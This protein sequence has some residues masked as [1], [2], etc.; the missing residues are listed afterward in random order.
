MKCNGCSP[1]MPIRYSAIVGNTAS[2]NGAHKQ[3]RRKV[4]DMTAR[5]PC[6]KPCL[7]YPHRIGPACKTTGYRVRDGCLVSNTAMSPTATD[8]LKTPIPPVMDRAAFT[9]R[10]HAIGTRS[11]GSCSGHGRYT[12]GSRGIVAFL[13]AFYK[14]EEC[15]VGERRVR[16]SVQS[17]SRNTHRCIMPMELVGAQNTRPAPTLRVQNGN[18]LLVSLSELGYEGRQPYPMTLLRPLHEQTV[19]VL[20]LPPPQNYATSAK[21]E[22]LSKKAPTSQ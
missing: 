7:R 19:G 17:R 12:G 5:K 18:R 1:D 13:S 15:V 16:L 6:V 9:A 2:C 4:L 11:R 22:N 3:K 21:V 8:S 10:K 20:V 14:R